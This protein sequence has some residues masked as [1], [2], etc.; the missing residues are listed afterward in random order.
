MRRNI[1]FAVVPGAL[2]LAAIMMNAEP[3]SSAPS[4]A[5]KGYSLTGVGEPQGLAAAGK[6]VWITNMGPRSDEDSVIRVDA[7]TGDETL[8]ESKDTTLLS[9]V[10]A[11]P[12]Y[13]WAVN[14]SVTNNE[15][16]SLLRI[17]ASS[18]AV[19]RVAIPVAD[20][21][22]GIDV[23]Q[24][25][26]FLA[27][28]SVW[29]P[30]TFGLLRVNTTT[31]KV[32]L[33]KSPLINGSPF[34]AAVDAH[35]L[36]LSAPMYLRSDEHYFVRVSL[37][38]GAVTKVNFAGVDGGS[39]IGDDGTNLWVENRAGVQQIDPST[40]H[41]TTITIS[42]DTPIDLES[43]AT[44]AATGDDIYFLA[45]LASLGRNGVV[46]IGIASGRAAALSS[47]LLNEPKM[48]AAANGVLWVV[49]FPQ[50]KLPTLVR[51]K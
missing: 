50:A 41:V 26:I 17:D 16:W 37:A 27:G 1:L 7:A 25:P 12:R 45:G 39:P 13:A 23:N 43:N 38:T 11:S 4:T 44:S 20:N 3:V 5:F 46:E 51:V 10:V 47:S 36:W 14:G 18:L 42:K 8:I 6:Y 2:M 30:G 49:N 40:G 48:L 35:D 24:T 9:Q 31:L 19:Q 22:G 34:G 28:D 15:S 29:V 32:S 21:P 33:I